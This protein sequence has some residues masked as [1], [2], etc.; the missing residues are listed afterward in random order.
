MPP[1]EYLN[2]RDS[3]SRI[4]HNPGNQPRFWA[5]VPKLLDV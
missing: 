5:E 3:A 4:L 2:I 1:S